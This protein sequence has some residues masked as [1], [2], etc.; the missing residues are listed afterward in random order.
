MADVKITVVS[1]PESM[2]DLLVNAMVIEVQN[3]GQ[4]YEPQVLA[5]AETAPAVMAALHEVTGLVVDDLTYDH[6]SYSLLRGEHPLY[7]GGGLIL[8]ISNE[9]PGF[10]AASNLA[11][12][13][14]FLSQDQL[15]QVRDFT[16]V[17][18]Q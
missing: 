8:E 13:T 14:E 3:Q 5:L 16:N 18:W 9:T 12:F 2:R 7:G 1:V 4:G 11:Q 15:T 10:I 17:I 6:G